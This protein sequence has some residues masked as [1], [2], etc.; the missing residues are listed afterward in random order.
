MFRNDSRPF[1]CSASMI[2]RSS[3]SIFR[4]GLTAP[5]RSTRSERRAGAKLRK[6]CGFVPSAADRVNGLEIPL[7][8][9]HVLRVPAPAEEGS[10]M[11]RTP[12]LRSLSGLASEHADAERLRLTPAELREQRAENAYSRGEFLKR[13]G[14]IGAAVAV[15]AVAGPTALARA[16]NATNPRVAIIGG[17]IAGLTAALTLQDKG[18][19]STVYEA[20]DRVG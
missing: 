14:A 13:T 16:A 17:G 19:A 5:R 18:V 11:P 10:C 12:L 1:S 9:A 20:S 4:S 6:A 7:R 3:A 8:I 15:A 2:R